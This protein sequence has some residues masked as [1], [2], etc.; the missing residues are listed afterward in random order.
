[1]RILTKPCFRTLLQYDLDIGNVS[2]FQQIKLN[3]HLNGLRHS[4][5]VAIQDGLNLIAFVGGRAGGV[6]LSAFFKRCELYH[7]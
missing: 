2:H 1:M 5:V 3:S 4:L 6:V 7:K